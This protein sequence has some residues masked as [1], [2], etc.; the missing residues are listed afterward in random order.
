[1]VYGLARWYAGLRGGVHGCCVWLIVVHGLESCTLTCDQLRKL[2]SLQHR[3]LR[4]I[5]GLVCFDGEDWSTR[6]RRMKARL[7]NVLSLHPVK[8]WSNRIRDSK[9]TMKRRIMSG[10]AP[11][12]TCNAVLW[13]P[14]ACQQLNLVEGQLPPRRF[15]GRPR[16][17]WSDVIA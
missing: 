9:R 7:S 12:L 3:M 11:L 4:R 13:H 15:C 5:V 1:M 17:R 2:D 16:A 14:I 10:E 8:P 6:G